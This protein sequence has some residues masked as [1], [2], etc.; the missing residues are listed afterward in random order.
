DVLV[1]T[2]ADATRDAILK[3]ID[4]QLVAPSGQG[5]VAFFYFAGHGSRVRNTLSA[6]SD[7]LDE[8]IVPADIAK[9]IRDIR[10]KELRR[11]FNSVL[12][13]GATLVA[14]FDSCHSGSVSRGL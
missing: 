8:S 3:A 14:V 12:D 4:T 1:L 6:E 7:K 10:D 9:G 2:D 11:V 5:D 13:R